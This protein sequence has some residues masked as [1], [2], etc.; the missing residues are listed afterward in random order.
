M[1]N[2]VECED[3]TSDE[4]WAGVV[5]GTHKDYAE[6]LTALDGFLMAETSFKEK[7]GNIVIPTELWDCWMDKLSDIGPSPHTQMAQ[8]AKDLYIA[9]LGQD[10]EAFRKAKL[11]FK[12]RMNALCM[13]HPEM[14]PGV[15]PPMRGK[16]ANEQ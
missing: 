11:K 3:T 14:F 6:R 12:H 7:D 4:Y 9:M 5:S 2:T 8:F 13:A 16:Q 15:E 10:G 1:S